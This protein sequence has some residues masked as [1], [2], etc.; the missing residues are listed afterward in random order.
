[1]QIFGN[2]KISVHVFGQLKMFVY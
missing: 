2:P 1:M